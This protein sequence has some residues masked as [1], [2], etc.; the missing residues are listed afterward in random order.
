MTRA[1]EEHAILSNSQTRIDEVIGAGAQRLVE[2]A[3][4]PRGLAASALIHRV[5]ATVEKYVLK[6][7]PQASAEQISS[8]IDGLHA[9]DL[10]LVI[11]CQ[12]GDQS[13]WS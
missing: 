12:R 9:D 5:R 1:P 10:C 7:E 3:D 11:A 4:N 2:R 8:F 13:A 6:H